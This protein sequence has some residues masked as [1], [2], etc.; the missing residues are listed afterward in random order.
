MTEA[1]RTLHLTRASHIKSLRQPWLIPGLIPL[2][3]LT[4]CAGRGGAGKSSWVLARIADLTHGRL[5]GDVRTP[6]DALIVGPEDD[7]SAVMVPRLIAA[8][9]DL[10]RVHRFEVRTTYEGGE[11]STSSPVMPLDV[12]RL[13]EA[14]EVTKAG[15]VMLDPAS[16][17]VS[18]DLNKREDVRAAMDRLA[19]VAQETRTAVVIV[20][21]FNKGAGSVSDKLTGSAAFRDAARSV[22][23]FA[24]DEET[25]DRIVSVD[26]SNYSAAAGES[27]AFRLESVDVPTDDG[28]LT[29]VARV[30]DLGVTDRTVHDVIN[31]GSEDEQDD[32]N[33]AQAF[34]LDYI[35]STEAQEA[36]AAD[37]IKA[38]R[39]AGFNESEMK[40]ARRRCRNP[41]IQSVKSAFG[42]GW[43][44]Q[45]DHEGVTE[46]VKGVTTLRPDTFDTLAD[47]FDGPPAIVSLFPTPR[48][49]Q[50][51]P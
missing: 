16:S 17:I 10:E 5:T 35:R 18:G 13:R 2:S 8:G 49:Q 33:A 14:I 27:L 42:A 40:N 46:G 50:E 39:G 48:H 12:D 6:T 51:T 4:V 7:W 38:G 9:A 32:R 26:K 37:V 28:E 1:A 34:V 22:L 11:S 41:K 25:G 23:V 47:A 31:R 3:T 44:W 24:E 43:V 45:L 19:T 30:I 21:H 20:S 15:L 36:N 29:Q